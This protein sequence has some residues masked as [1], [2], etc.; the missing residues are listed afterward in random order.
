[1]VSAY[2]EVNASLARYQAAA[3]LEKTAAVAEDSVTKSYQNGLSTLTDALSAQKA[4]S[5]ASGAKEQAFAEALISATMLA[6]AS[7]QL[8]SAKTVPN[9]S[10]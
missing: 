9:L 4:R 5:L 6:F 10:N 3:S 8:G 7:G 1:M 2:N